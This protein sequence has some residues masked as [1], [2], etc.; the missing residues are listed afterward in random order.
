MHT[1][2]RD[3]PCYYLSAVAKDRLPVFR[4]DE[5]KLVT[6]AA[7]DEARRSGQFALYAYVIMPDHFHV[8][9]NS[10]LS[11]SRTLQFLNGITGR[12]VIDYLKEHNFESSLMKLRHETRRREYS[13]SLWDHHP[14][15]RLLLTENMLMQR[16]HYT[17]N[18]P[19]RGGL[20]SRP[21]DYRWSSVRCWNGNMR[22][23]E[24]LMMD[25]DQIK[26]RRS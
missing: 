5:I 6:C 13:Y 7:I 23:D 1:I 12:R 14:D 20:V 17:H 19:V 9:T 24:P 3:S 21:E 26:W 11:P 25:I 18:N 10:G 2:S 15:A 16:V 8:I 22:D 4:T